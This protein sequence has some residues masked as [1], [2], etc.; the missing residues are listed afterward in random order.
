[1]DDETP[2][3][4]G[5]AEPQPAGDSL[6]G[7]IR[8]LVDEVREYASA[9]IAFQKTRAG[10]A[11]KGLRGVAPFALLAVMFVF[12]ALMALPV[13]LVLALAPLVGPWVA[14]AIA[15]AA[16]LAIAVAFGAVAAL[17]WRGTVR[18]LRTGEHHDG[19]A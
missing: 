13:G 2:R 1:M 16:L 15:V 4:A 6:A 10:A 19:Q 14:T 3:P 18:V 5:D 9:E 12:L 11:G 7:D 17:K 8:Q